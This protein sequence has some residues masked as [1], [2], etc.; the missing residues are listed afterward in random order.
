M[1][2]RTFRTCGGELVTVTTVTANQG[3]HMEHSSHVPAE[4]VCSLEEQTDNRTAPTQPPPIST[5]APQAPDDP[6][7][8]L[9]LFLADSVPTSSDVDSWN[10]T[11][12]TNPLSPR[13]HAKMEVL[14]EEEAAQ[15]IQAPPF[16]HRTVSALCRTTVSLYSGDV[17]S[18]TPCQ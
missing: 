7:G 15:K 12:Q 6:A 8:R 14:P 5:T 10:V 4:S 3:Y 11:I 1:P 18:E 9:G 13:S 17:V 16:P 2:Q